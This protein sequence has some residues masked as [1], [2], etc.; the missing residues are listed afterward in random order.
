MRASV[1]STAL[2]DPKCELDDGVQIGPYA[3]IGGDVK[4]GKETIIGPQVLIEGWGRIG[5]G[6]RINNGVVIGTSPQ[7][8]NFEEKRS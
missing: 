7:D 5:K 3:I 1:H 6:C 2:V 8:T 4:I